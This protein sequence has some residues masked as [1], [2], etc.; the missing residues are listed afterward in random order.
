MIVGIDIGGTNTHGVLFDRKKLVAGISVKGNE[1]KHVRKCHDYLV[2]KA[3]G[4]K[5]RLVFTGGGSRKVTRKDIGEPF[6]IMSEIKAIGKGGMFLSGK[7]NIFTV[8]IGTGTAFVSVKNSRSVHVGGTGMGGGT[9]QG[10]SQLLLSSSITQTEKMSKKGYG[11]LDLTVKDIVGSGVGRIPG[12]ATASN[13]GS[14]GRKPPKSEIAHSLLKM[15]GETIGVMAYF[16]AKSVS[17][18]KN[19][20]VCGR[21]AMNGIVKKTVT[22]TVKLMGGMATVPKN[23]EYCAAIGAALG[24]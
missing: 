22:E 23:A 1:L 3:N 11:R 5:Y 19:I 21:V 17:Q 10:L 12:D 20:L 15:A 4:K 18:E 7:K 8:S 13:F 14:V 2:R 16:A 24:S 6:A 9:L